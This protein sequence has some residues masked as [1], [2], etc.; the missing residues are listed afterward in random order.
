[1]TEKLDAK[2]RQRESLTNLRPGDVIRYPSDVCQDVHAD[3]YL[4]V[5]SVE[6]GKIYGNITCNVPVNSIS[7]ENLLEKG[8]K[9]L[10]AE[11]KEI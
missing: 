3:T 8:A 10:K 7:I 5:D 1:M 2:S 11:W 6:D 9:I 4:I